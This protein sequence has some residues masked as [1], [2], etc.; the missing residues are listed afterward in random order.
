M[1]EGLWQLIAA[2]MLPAVGPVG[3]AVVAIFLAVAFWTLFRDEF[4]Q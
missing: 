4:L 1:M 3:G 2:I